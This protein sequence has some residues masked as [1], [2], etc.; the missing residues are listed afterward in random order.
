MFALPEVAGAEIAP[1]SELLALEVEL[2]ARG[3]AGKSQAVAA[4]VTLSL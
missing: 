4:S 1:E 2:A 3:S